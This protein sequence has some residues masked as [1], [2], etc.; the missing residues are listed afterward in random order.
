[1]LSY[2][3]PE[4]RGFYLGLLLML[5]KIIGPWLTVCRNMVCDA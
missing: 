5:D 2:P 4:N 3:K 1:M